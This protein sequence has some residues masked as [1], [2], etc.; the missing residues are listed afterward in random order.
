MLGGKS[1]SCVARSIAVTASPSEPREIERERDGGKLPLTAH[2]KRGHCFCHLGEHVQ[3]H[4]ASAEGPDIEKLQCPRTLL[5]L[6]HHFQHDTILVQL[7][8]HRG[9]LPLAERVVQSIDNDLR[10]DAHA[11]RRVAVDDEHG[12][13]PLVL[14][15]AAHVAQFGKRL[16]DLDKFGSPP[17]QL[18]GIRIFEGVLVLRPAHAIFHRE[19]LHRLQ[20]QGDPFDPRQLRLQAADDVA[21]TDPP[22]AERR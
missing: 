17:V 16:Q 21:C 5:K 6:R 20:E 22:L 13:Q 12:R 9:H 7:G 10:G 11:R 2:H 19:I 3:W 4:L 14:L 15:I 18:I 8:K 1:I